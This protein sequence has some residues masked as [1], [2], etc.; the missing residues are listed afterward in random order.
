MTLSPGTQP[1]ANTASTVEPAVFLVL[2]NMN[3]RE[4][5][6]IM[7]RIEGGRW[8]GFAQ[9]TVQRKQSAM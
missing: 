3:L 7:G 9:I 5:E 8:S 4:Y 1:V 2:I 6:M